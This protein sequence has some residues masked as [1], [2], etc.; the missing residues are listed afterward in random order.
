MQKL[1]LNTNYYVHLNIYILL[2]FV[3]MDDRA[4]Y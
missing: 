1:P 4:Y 2:F 3:F